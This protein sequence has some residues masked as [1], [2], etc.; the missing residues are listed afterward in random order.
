[1]GPS[2]CSAPSA[3]RGP[4]IDDTMKPMFN[5]RPLNARMN[6]MSRN[7]TEELPGASTP[8]LSAAV[9]ASIHEITL[10]YI[11][12]LAA[13]R[14]AAATRRGQL[15]DWPCKPQGA[16]ADMSLSARVSLAALPYTLF[17]VGFE[18]EKLWR[19]LGEPTALA[20]SL[21]TGERYTQPHRESLQASL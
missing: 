3:G 14:N 9:L 7:V 19:S 17:S 4:A 13:D 20:G 11:E 5:A 6:S 1:G 21:S 2:L 8:V 12:L 16:I 15:Q 18:D 10:D